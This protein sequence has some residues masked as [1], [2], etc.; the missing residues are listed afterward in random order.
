MAPITHRISFTLPS[1]ARKVLCGPVPMSPLWPNF[2][3]RPYCINISCLVISQ[4]GHAASNLC[5][6]FLESPFFCL[7]NSNVS[8][9]FYF[10]L[11]R[12]ISAFPNWINHSWLWAVAVAHAIVPPLLHSKLVFMSSSFPLDCVFEG[13]N[14][15]I[16]IF[17]SINFWPKVILSILNRH[18]GSNLECLAGG[19]MLGRGTG[20]PYVQ[21]SRVPPTWLP[22]FLRAVQN[23][24]HLPKPHNIPF[25][26]INFLNSFLPNCAPIS[27]SAWQ[28]S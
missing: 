13:R 27:F 1:K 4:G 16:F 18:C 20:K 22:C 12:A 24:P 5:S 26:S 3:L 10:F 25:S 2:P 19:F 17:V 7:V 6:Q 15:V 28:I 9:Y 23:P 11:Y 14:W 21:P 8:F